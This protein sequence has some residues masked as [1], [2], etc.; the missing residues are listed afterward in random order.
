MLIAA[1]LVSA[2]VLRSLPAAAVAQESGTP[3]A[4]ALGAARP[5]LI[6]VP[7][8]P[9]SSLEA[10]VADHIR[11]AAG[12]LEGSASARRNE[13]L[14]ADAYGELAE[15]LHAYEF[16]DSAEAAYVNATRVAPRDVRWR[17]LLGYL[18]QQTG[19]FE[20]A[21]EAFEQV[22]RLDPA[23]REAAIRLGDVY[24]QLNRLREARERFDEVLQVFPA[25]ARNGLGEVALREGRFEEAVRHFAA[26]LDRVPS[27]TAV[28]YS[29]GMAYRGLGQADRARDH[30][31][32]RGNGT[33]TVGDPLVDALQRLVRGERT[34]VMQGRRAYEAGQF[35]AAAEA[36]GRA[37]SAAP[38]SA[39]ARLNFGLTLARLGKAADAASQFE[40]ALRLDPA[41]LEARAALGIVLADQGRDA[42]S[43]E[44]LRPAF[45]QRPQ[46][47]NV[48]G[49]L[50]RVLIRSRRIDDAIAVL[51]RVSSLDP[52][53]E[54]TVVSLA[55]L[56]A[57]RQRFREAVTLL[58]EANRRFPERSPTATTLARLL[59]SSPDRSIRDGQ[60][61]LDL[62]TAVYTADAAAVHAETVALALSELA[63][64]AEALQWLRRG[65]ADAERAKNASDVARLKGELPR[66]SAASCRP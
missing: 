57:D 66:Y 45:E 41:N 64:C 19:R 1:V 2:T 54:E 38:D 49:A 7:L 58:D 35:P 50:V 23:R 40:A 42:D 33:L 8:P 25:L 30:L 34:L 46:D 62:A 43:L 60:R 15:I 36:F 52:D 20:E 32:R 48:R 5:G 16:F 51:E 14:L 27:A 4:P 3:A 11:A 10:A 9:L 47:L 56:F 17:Y 22:R 13:R 21:A 55:I 26:V 29:L 63:R 6:A 61:A 53:N 65:I 18:F 39:T 37:V 12:A 44:H 28:H 24:L 59:A 31:Q